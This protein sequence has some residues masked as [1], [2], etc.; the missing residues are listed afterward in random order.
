MILNDNPLIKATI[1]HNQLSS[2]Q[3]DQLLN[4]IPLGL[5]FDKAV[6]D[7]VNKLKEA[8][9]K[10]QKI[11]I[12]GDYDCDGLC[13]TSILKDSL[14][15]LGAQVG[16]YIPNRFK[17]GYGINVEIAKLAIDKNYDCVIL[18]DN[19][20][21]AFD[22]IDYL[23]SF[24]K[25]VIVV[26][27]HEIHQEVKADFLLHPDLLSDHYK[28]M[29]T[30]GLV[31]LISHHLVGYK[32]Y[33]CA[34]AG[35]ATVGDMMPLWNYNRTLLIESLKEMNQNKFLQITSLLKNSLDIIDEDVCAFQ[36]VPKLNAVG[37]LA[38]MANPNRIVDY[39]CLKDKADI[40]NFSMQILK[41]NE[42]RKNIHQV[43]IE[44]A[45]QLISDDEVIIIYDE[46]FH[47]GVVGIT[48]G[49][50]SNQYKKVSLVMHD[51]GNR[52]KGSVRSYGGI[53]LRELFDPALD[54]VLKFGGHHAAAG[55]ELLKE[56]FEEFKLRVNANVKNFLTFE[57]V[58]DSINYSEDLLS[59]KNIEELNQLKPFGMGFKVLPIL[60]QDA[61]VQS[62]KALKTGYK[63][64]IR[65]NDKKFD[66]LD[67]STSLKINENDI[68]S[69]SAR[70]SI[71]EYRGIKSITLFVEKW[72]L[73]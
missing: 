54:L 68:V 13:S 23:R 11:F 50:L 52:L 19:G 51:D 57:E 20:V 66:C 61:Y 9:N 60:F 73:D 8:I 40:I 33:Y 49:Q 18:L 69:L 29:C 67:F 22:T 46:S 3:I 17:D 45:N 63:V 47:E 41:I 6:M 55:I 27:H 43:M 36:I 14:S 4:P 37:R 58:V 25:D 16:F 34:L 24:H 26:D 62:I 10:K 39:L 53:P 71:N 56:N 65:I 7:V 30:S 12:C 59:I 70:Y 21:S 5:C 64:T 15:L 35:I 32:P 31:F 38:D 42:Q 44:K 72:N 2:Q 48:A 28:A 1:E